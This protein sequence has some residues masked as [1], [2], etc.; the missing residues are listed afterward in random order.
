MNARERNVETEDRCA[1]KLAYSRGEAKRVAAALKQKR[2]GEPMEA[3]RCPVADHWHVGHSKPVRR[4]NLKSNPKR[5][6]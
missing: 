5:A 6:S 4:L 2:R 3:Y 1:E